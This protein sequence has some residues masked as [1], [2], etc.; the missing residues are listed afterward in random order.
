M[1][2]ASHLSE[3][4]IRHLALRAIPELLPA[5]SNGRATRTWI[6]RTFSELPDQLALDAAAQQI[7]AEVRTAFAEAYSDLI[8]ENRLTK[9]NPGLRLSRIDSRHIIATIEHANAENA[10]GDDQLIAMYNSLLAIDRIFDIEDLQG[11]PKR[12]WFIIGFGA[13]QQP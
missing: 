1:T 3:N 6:I 5:Q 2:S 4:S 10:F 12:F 13:R 9:C 7:E 8:D 11:Y